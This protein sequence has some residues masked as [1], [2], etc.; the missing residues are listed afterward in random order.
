[1]SKIAPI[2]W[3]Q[4]TLKNDYFKAL[5]LLFLQEKRNYASDLFELL[6]VSK[7]LFDQLRIWA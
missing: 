1:M 6:L 5:F 2:I 7:I 3:R 4:C